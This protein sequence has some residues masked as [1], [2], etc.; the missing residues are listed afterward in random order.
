MTELNTPGKRGNTVSQAHP[1]PQFSLGCMASGVGYSNRSIDRLSRGSVVKQNPAISHAAIEAQREKQRH[2]CL[3]FL[4]VII[5]MVG[6]LSLMWIHEDIAH[7]YELEHV[8]ELTL[9]KKSFGAH[10]H[11]FRNVKDVVEI[12][13]WLD[14]GLLPTLVKHTDPVLPSISYLDLLLFL[15]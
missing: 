2:S 15:I 9:T 5:F 8:M 1:R 7:I 11:T 10:S 6:F 12:W 4:L 14:F 3:E 13:E